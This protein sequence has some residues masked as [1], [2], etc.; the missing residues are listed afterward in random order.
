MAEVARGLLAFFVLL[1]LLA[2]VPY[3]LWLIDGWPWSSNLVSLDE[4]TSVPT[5]PDDGSL[6]VA[7]LTV[8]GWIGWL[9]FAIAVVVEI[10]AVVRGVRAPRIPTLGPQQRAAAMLIS[11]VIG[12][13]VG[14]ATMAGSAPAAASASTVDDWRPVPT[15]P[16]DTDDDDAPAPDGPPSPHAY[17]EPRQPDHTTYVVESGDT[18]WDIADDHLHDPT[19]YPEIAE[20]SADTIQPDGRRLTDPDLIYPGWELTIP[21]DTHVAEEVLP[22]SGRRGTDATKPSRAD[23]PVVDAAQDTSER[24]IPEGR[25]VA[26]ANSGAEPGHD[27]QT[28]TARFGH[29]GDAQDAT[30]GS[31]TDGYSVEHRL[32][33]DPAAASPTDSDIDDGGPSS[34]VRTT[35]GIGSFLAAGVITLLT[36]RRVLQQRRRK[37]GQRVPG[38][39]P[40][41]AAAEAE[42]RHVG[43]PASVALVDRALRTLARGMATDRQALPALRAVRVCRDQ[44]ELYLAEPAE[45]PAPF[46]GSS[47][48]TVWALTSAAEEALDKT[49]EWPAPFPSLVTVGHDFDGAHVMLDLEHVGTLRVCGDD[50]CARAF[51]TALAAEYALSRWADDVQVTLIGAHPDLEAMHTG[52]VRHV[53][54]I[55]HLLRSL[56]MRAAADRD[57]STQSAV[58]DVSGARVAQKAEAIWTP[59]ILLIATPL[60]TAQ[61][62]RLTALV[63]QRPRLAIAAVTTDMEMPADWTLRINGA[64]DALLE[65]LGVALRPQQLNDIM[66]THIVGLLS[67]A[68]ADPVGAVTPELALRDVPSAGTAPTTLPYADADD[69]RGNGHTGGHDTMPSAVE[70]A[71]EQPPTETRP[72][73]PGLQTQHPRVLLLGEPDVV[74][75]T[76][77]LDPTKRGQAVQVAA[78]LSL[79]PA[80]SIHAMDEAIWPASRT[81]K[82]RAV[83][84]STLRRWL[85]THPSGAAYLPHATDRYE[86]HADIRSDWHDWCELLADGPEGASIEALQ[87]AL[88]LVRARPFSGVRSRSYAWADMY[89]QEMIAAI[90][91]AAHELAER[92][93]KA[94]DFRAAQT[95]AV[96]GLDIEPGSELLWRDRLKA[97]VR[98][99]TRASA[100]ALI[101]RLR[102]LA[103]ELGGDLEEDTVALI[104]QIEN[105]VSAKYAG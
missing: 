11:A 67:S 22:D 105:P 42:L 95:A 34:L 3:G 69:H 48:G 73:E 103:D 76:G 97:E 13:S 6:F 24:N 86:L 38:P 8:L 80:R 94:G 65:P 49:G 29:H 59:E 39:Q 23:E 41:A 81:P 12:I 100:L 50:A 78:Y 102:D 18:L 88:G 16:A 53:T 28:D 64:D 82:T 70:T 36:A 21:P 96:R 35:A 89:A 72:A 79:R 44:I 98:L 20:A 27:R 52:R 7:T 83:A 9:T 37:Y 93:L 91:D 31:T 62:D 92:A 85:G 104:E 68:D 101:A 47:D 71:H 43:D 25:D 66:Y 63:D 46:S 55:D 60:T 74:G 45:L 87:R 10:P 61:R 51:M 14:S 57:L 58:D 15:A 77:P 33:A 54:D 99:G 90:V 1:C 5:T 40:D 19:R 26:N 30:T 75:A 17:D 2:G 56:A 4:I 32:A 84:V